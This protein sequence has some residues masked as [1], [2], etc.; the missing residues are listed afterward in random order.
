MTESEILLLISG[1]AFGAQGM[2]AFHM[3]L[4][5]RLARRNEVVA[6]RQRRINTADAYLSSFRIYRLQHRS[7][8]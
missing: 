7:R 3:L 1:I 5:A 6:L 8:A 2:N 4:D